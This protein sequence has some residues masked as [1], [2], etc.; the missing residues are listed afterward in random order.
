MAANQ[1]TAP[2]ECF[3]KL[4]PT[5][6]ENDIDD[7]DK[8]EVLELLKEEDF[9]LLEGLVNIWCGVVLLK[10]KGMQMNLVETS[11]QN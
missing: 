6:T 4:D 5:A 1:L 11:K 7:T 9:V 2:I 8:Y 3:K 10:D